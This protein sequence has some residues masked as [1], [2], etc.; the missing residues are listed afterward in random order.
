VVTA[1]YDAPRYLFDTH[2]P[3]I[4][5][6]SLKK[7][8]EAAF[9]KRMQTM[10]EYEDWYVGGDTVSKYIFRNPGEKDDSFNAR[11][12][13]VCHMNY[14][15][16]IVDEIVDD[17][18]GD[19]VTR[20]YGAGEEAADAR[21]KDTLEWNNI[22]DTQQ[23]WCRSQV[24][25]GE[26]W[27]NVAWRENPG[28]VA[29]FGVHPMDA[30]WRGDPDNPGHMI[31]FVETRASDLPNLPADFAGNVYVHWI[32]N[33]HEY[34]QVDNN[35]DYIVPPTP[36]KYG[37]IP[38]I[39]WKGRSVVGYDDGL[40]YV[41]DAVT[42]QKLVLNRTSDEDKLVRYQTHGLLVIQSIDRPT[43]ESGAD[44]F[45]RITDPT[46]KAYFINP[47]ADIA[48]VSQSRKDLVAALFE[49]S[50]VPMSL[51]VGGTASSGLQLAIEMRPLTRVVRSVETKATVSERQLLRVIAAVGRAHGDTAYPERPNPDVQFS[52][53]F[54]PSDEKQEFDKDLSMLNNIPPLITTEDF[55][56]RHHKHLRNN[57]E[58]MAEYRKKLD[59]Q[60]KA[61]SS[62][63]GRLTPPEA[64]AGPAAPIDQGGRPRDEKPLGARDVNA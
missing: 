7:L 21:L 35:G 25:L 40:S 31:E 48:A 56:A 19:E 28:T 33:E 9:A 3:E 60:D 46:G 8:Q 14:I 24:L 18:Y 29:I 43:I 12:R 39:R 37:V 2:S 5:R 61:G 41:R 58:A 26:G 62:M 15:G 53:N 36:N 44:S 4:L 30:W 52:H 50:S 13:R 20:S 47:G 34:C 42:I 54:L 6:A 63:F 27:A 38:Y 16:R 10:Q 45:I 57:P 64:P 1:P 23:D 51:V 22:V 11:I 49:I 55:L 59:E 17:V 32:W